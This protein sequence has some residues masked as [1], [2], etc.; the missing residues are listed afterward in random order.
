MTT[1]DVV[2]RSAR[3]L[4][5]RRP[6]RSH[7]AAARM[8]AERHLLAR[9]HEPRTRRD[10]ILCYHGVGTPSWGV[11]DISPDRFASQ[12]DLARS[13]GYQFVPAASIVDTPPMPGRPRLAITFD[14]GLRSVATNAAPILAE[15][16]IHWTLFVVTDWAEGLHTMPP[17]TVLGWDT[18]ADLMA[19]GVTIGSHSCSHPDFSLLGRDAII[20]ELTRSR[21]L[22]RTRLGLSTTDFA[23]PFGQSGN[24]PL[25]AGG[26]AVRAGY[27]RIYAQS[28]TRRPPTTVARTFISRFDDERIFLAALSG[29]FDRWEEWV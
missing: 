11:N 9:T 26:A 27:R 14:D 6:R 16:G 4:G 29:G 7:V 2:R 8:M 17:D 23:I 19:Q 28:E 13:L 1:T 21:E 20:E 22:V 15:R 24:W 25:E 3:R 10:R 18:L 12:I 5:L